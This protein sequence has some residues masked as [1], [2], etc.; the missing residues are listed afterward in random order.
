MKPPGAS[1]ESFFGFYGCRLCPVFLFF[2]QRNLKGNCRAE[3]MAVVIETKESVDGPAGRVVI[4]SLALFNFYDGRIKAADFGTKKKGC[5][6]RPFVVC[7][8]SNSS[9]SS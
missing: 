1:G 7:N 9:S 8:C 5:R 2:Y 3:G 4:F 6:S